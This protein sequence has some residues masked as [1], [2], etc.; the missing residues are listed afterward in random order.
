MDHIWQDMA[1]RIMFMWGDL[2]NMTEERLAMVMA[3]AWG[4]DRAAAVLTT[5]DVL[6][7]AEEQFDTEL[8]ARDAR[9]ILSLLVKD[10]E[11]INSFDILD[12]HIY[13]LIGDD[14]D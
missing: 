6:K 3:D 12:D 11:G 13:D 7:R 2:I 5:N 10:L 14:N 8:S 4:Q 1:K 9:T